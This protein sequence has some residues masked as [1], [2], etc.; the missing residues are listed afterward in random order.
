MSEGVSIPVASSEAPIHLDVTTG[1]YSV[2]VTETRL[3]DYCRRQE[4]SVRSV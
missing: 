4:L 1:L 2:G 3:G